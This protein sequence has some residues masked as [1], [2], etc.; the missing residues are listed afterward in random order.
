MQKTLRRLRPADIAGL[1]GRDGKHPDGGSL[2]L[3]VRAGRGAWV[4]EH[5]DG[6]FR[7]SRG[8]GACPP[9]TL[10]M[11]RKLA[12]DLRAGRETVPRRRPS[13][14]VTSKKT[15]SQTV[16]DYLAEKAGAWRGGIEG[17][18][19][20]SYR[21]RLTGDKADVGKLATLAVSAITTDDVKTALGRWSD[22]PATWSKVA[23][24]IER[25]LDWAI[26]MKLRSEPNPARLVG[27]LEH[28][29]PAAK[30]VVHHKAMA[31]ADVPDLMG[32]LA[33]LGGA[34][35]TALAFTIL[36]AVRSGETLGATWAE[37]GGD[38]WTIGEDRMKVEGRE[39][40]VPLTPEAIAL[41]GKRGEPGDFIFKNKR[42]LKLHDHAMQER[43]KTLRAGVT[44]HGMRSTFKDWA[45]EAGYPPELSEMALA[46]TVGDDTE[47]AYRR[48]DMID[49][50][51]EMMMAWTKFVAGPKASV[52]TMQ[53]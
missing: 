21:V 17:D 5:R 33:D 11:A 40:R 15:F 18:E 39:H 13:A 27:L 42:G 45:M 53:N 43:L 51:R 25:V 19:A 32:E 22:N 47:R 35:C 7:R 48:T 36:T 37:I 6:A 29:R 50:R 14:V 49:K 2:Y 26:A 31:A 3:Q 16:L 38:T 28:F 44:V 30:P 34:V 23:G 4:Y 46:H 24:R 12:D 52:S 8:L 9:V 20:K 1:L 41:L 10:P